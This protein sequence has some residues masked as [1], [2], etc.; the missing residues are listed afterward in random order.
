LKVT[1]RA[2]AKVNLLLDAGGAEDSPDAACGGTCPARFHQVDLVFQEISLHDD[3]VVEKAGDFSVKCAG[4]IR[5]NTAE[6]AARLFFEKTEMLCCAKISITKRIPVASGLGGGS[7]DAAAVIRALDKLYG[8]ELTK[9]EMM[10]LGRAV[11]SDVCFFLEGGC[12]LARGREFNLTKLEPKA[13]FYVL[14][15]TPKVRLPEKKTAWVYSEYDKLAKKKRFDAEKMA[16]AVEYGDATD[17]ASLLGNSLEDVVLAAFPECAAAKKRML[18]KGALG[19]LV[20]GAGPTV[21]GIF[22]KRTAG[23]YET[24]A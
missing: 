9:E 6:K 4:N 15:E 1:E 12:C 8:T 16:Y 13:G 2:D 17:V 20:S 7:S 22:D 11:G 23:A 10:E 19:A 5:N 14:L 24:V 21:F 3:V 18:E